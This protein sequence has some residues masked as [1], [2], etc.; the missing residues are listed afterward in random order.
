VVTAEI[1][2]PDDSEATPDQWL[3]EV[4]GL[5]LYEPVL[6]SVLRSELR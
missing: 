5:R 6:A 2:V 1:T 4:V 3:S